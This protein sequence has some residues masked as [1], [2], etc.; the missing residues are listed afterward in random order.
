MSAAMGN[1]A[2]YTALRDGEF[3]KYRAAWGP[4]SN[5]GQIVVS[6]AHV[7]GPGAG[8]VLLTVVTTTRGLVQT[9]YR[10]EDRSVA[11]I[12]AAT[13]RIHHILTKSSGGDQPID[14]NTT[15]DYASRLARYRDAGNPKRDRDIPIPE[16]EPLDLLS[17]LIQTRDW[18]LSP[19]DTR[20]ALVYAGRALYPVTIHAEKFETVATPLGRKEALV[21]VPRMD[22]GEPFGMFKNGGEIKVWVGRDERRLPV[23]MT[24]HLRFGTATL[25]LEEHGV[26]AKSATGQQTP[27]AGAAPASNG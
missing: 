21:L 5:A 17:A 6:S 12:D 23:K 20:D 11:E 2:P 8:T 1:A 4:F 13:G 22:R 3:L 9:F 14:A 26:Q 10:Y 27:A 18:N 7:G 19:G 16:G 15:F 24:L 25:L